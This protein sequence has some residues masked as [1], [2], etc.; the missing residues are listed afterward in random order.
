M[1]EFGELVERRHSESSAQCLITFD[2]LL[3]GIEPAGCPPPPGPPVCFGT[4]GS[5]A[6]LGS[7]ARAAGKLPRFADGVKAI[8]SWRSE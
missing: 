2:P 8:C 5:P 4:A 1:P 7:G 3:P 6:W